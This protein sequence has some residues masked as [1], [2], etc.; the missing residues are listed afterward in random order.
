MPEIDEPSTWLFD[1]SD[2]RRDLPPAEAEQVAAMTI[3]YGDPIYAPLPETAV[4]AVTELLRG[5]YAHTPYRRIAGV[6]RTDERTVR[7]LAEKRSS[8]R[9]DT[10]WRPAVHSAH[11]RDIQAE[12][13]EYFGPLWRARTAEEAGTVLV[14]RVIG[15]EFHYSE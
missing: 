12:L 7:V 14:G 4:E 9:E 15:R 11:V 2:P 10:A 6:E 5:F 13:T 8:S 3:E 1:G